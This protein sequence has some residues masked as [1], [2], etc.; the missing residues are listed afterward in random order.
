MRIVTTQRCVLV[1]QP[2][3]GTVIAQCTYQIDQ[4]IPEAWESAVRSGVL[5]KL[6]EA[7][8]LC[9]EDEAGKE[10]DEGVS[11]LERKSDGSKVDGD[12]DM[13]VELSSSYEAYERQFSEL[14]NDTTRRHRNGGELV[15]TGKEGCERE[16]ASKK[17]E[18]D[19]ETEITITNKNGIRE[20]DYIDN[21]E[22]EEEDNAEVKAEATE[23]GTATVAHASICD[24]GTPQLQTT[25]ASQ[26]TRGAKPSSPKEDAVCGGGGEVASAASGEGDA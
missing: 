16:E 9:E 18:M 19:D 21:T 25:S 4:S 2:G 23:A 3:T 8:L 1:S 13:W 7:L 17:A 12:E 5:V 10:E 20:T 24:H 26:R 14:R 22:V 6:H 11:V 15:N